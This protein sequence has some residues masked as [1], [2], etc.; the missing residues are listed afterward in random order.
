MLERLRPTCS[1]I[2]EENMRSF[3]KMPMKLAYFVVEMCY[4]VT[5]ILEE[6]KV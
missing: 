2:L 6:G 4:D 3:K 1:F 5:S